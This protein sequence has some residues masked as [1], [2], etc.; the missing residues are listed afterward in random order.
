MF[1][2]SMH[3]ARRGWI[4]EKEEILKRLA[5]IGNVMRVNAD[6]RHYKLEDHGKAFRREA[7]LAEARGA[8]RRINQGEDPITILTDLSRKI[9]GIEGNWIVRLLDHVK[10]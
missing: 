6:P 10:K 5:V 8:Y 2:I 1:R 9:S 4:V 7:D 3:S